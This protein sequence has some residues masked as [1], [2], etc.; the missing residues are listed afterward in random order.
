MPGGGGQNTTTQ[1]ADPWSGQQ[2]FLLD[3]F[4]QAQDRFN[5]P[6]PSYFPGSTVAGFTGD[7][8]QAQSMARTAAGGQNQ[9]A[10]MGMQN[11]SN[12]GA[13]IDPNSNPFFQNAVQGA[14]RPVMQQF[15]DQGGPLAAIRSGMGASGQYGSS[16]QGIA[17]GIATARLGQSVM[18]TTAQMGSAAYGQGLDAAAR[19]AAL[20]PGIQAAQATGATTLDAVGQQNQG[21]NQAFLNDSIS[22]WNWDQQLPDAKLAQYQNLIQGT[23]GGNMTGTSEGAKGNPLMGG[24][25]GAASGYA[26]ASM[27]PALG[28]TGPVGAG[29]G[30]LLGLFGS[31]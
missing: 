4:K 16:R 27:M 31:M 8:V 10:A 26:L 1:K 17:E 24:I 14:I 2:P 25:G 6:G 18:D 13:A 7:T 12:L 11:L 5:A 20:T 22:R 29:I 15:T 21:M 19:A 9:A 23:F 3:I 28:I 30:L